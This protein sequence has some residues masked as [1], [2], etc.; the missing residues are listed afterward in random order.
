MESAFRWRY[1][2]SCTASQTRRANTTN[3][4]ET[5]QLDMSILSPNA[6]WKIGSAY[7]LS[8]VA[9][10]AFGAH[11]LKS[12]NMP[13]Q[14]IKNWETASHYLLVHSV[15]LLGISLHPRFARA[16]YTAPFIALGTL[17][18]SGSIYGLVLGSPSLRKILG[19]VTPLGGK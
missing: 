1:L 18:F 9:L 13:E 2:G 4:D 12:R 19:P 6:I 11:G 14:S 16:R 7:G 8:A 10:G 15:V 17:M 5:R 3:T